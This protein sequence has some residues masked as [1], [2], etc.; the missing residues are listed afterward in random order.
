MVVLL[1]KMGG[2]RT[3]KLGSMRSV[4]A[5]MQGGMS[6]ILGP[7]IGVGDE[8]GSSVITHLGNGSV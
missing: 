4:G 8:R 6:Y 2:Y 5:R 7:D 3:T 1:G